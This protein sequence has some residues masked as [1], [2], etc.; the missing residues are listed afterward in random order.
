MGPLYLVGWRG[1]GHS[2][3]TTRVDMDHPR[4]AGPAS[5]DVCAYIA[6][7]TPRRRGSLRFLLVLGSWTCIRCGRAAF[8]C[9]WPLRGLSGAQRK[10]I[11][12]Q[13]GPRVLVSNVSH[14]P[15]AAHQSLIS[16]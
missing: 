8:V 12:L 7:N 16:L 15:Y 2:I 5:V 13:G 3:L 4:V 9:E 11:A 6:R 14:M 1:T 10:I